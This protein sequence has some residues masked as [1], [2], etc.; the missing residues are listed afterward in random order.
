MAELE[1]ELVTQNYSKSLLTAL[2]STRHINLEDSYSLVSRDVG[3][4]AESR[5]RQVVDSGS[6]HVYDFNGE[7]YLDRLDIGRVLHQSMSDVKGLHFE[8][9][10]SKEGENPF[11]S[12]GPYQETSLLIKDK[13]GNEIFR[14]DDALFPSSWDNPVANSIIAQ[15]YFFKPN[16][17][18]WKQAINDKTGKD[19]EFS[20]V[21][22]IG[23]VTNFIVDEGEKLGYFQSPED[24]KVFADE[25]RWLQINQR[26]AFNSPVQFNA[27]IFNEYGI[28]GNKGISYFRDSKTGEVIRMEEGEYIHPQSHA[29]FIKGPEDTL[30][31]ILGH[32]SDEGA[33]FRNGSGIGQDIGVLRG[34]GEPLSGGG[35]SSGTLSFLKIYDNAAGSIKSGGKSRRAARMTTMKYDHADAIELIRAKPREDHKALILMKAGYEGGMDGEAVRTVSLQN[36]NLSVRA[37][38]E[39]FEKVR[40]GGKVK[41]R[42]VV[43]GAVVDE[44]DAHRMLQEIAYGSWRIGDPAIQYNTKIQEMH[45]CKNSGEQNSTNP[46]SEYLFLDDTSC[47][48]GSHNLLSYSDDKG[49]FDIESYKRAVRITQI[50]QDILNDASSYPVKSIAEISPEFRTTGVGYCNLGALLMRKGLAYDSDEGRAFT[51]AVTA[52]HT[53]TAY[54]ASVEMAE[55]LGT[56]VH[57]E[58]NKKP[59]LE[60]L[61][62]HKSSLDDVDWRL[63]NE[64]GL[65]EAAYG[66]W[67]KVVEGALVHGVRNAQT[68]NLAPTG[69]IS[70]LM[71]ADTTGIEPGISLMIYKS[72][73]GGGSVQLVNKEVPRA[74]RNLGYSSDQ[75]G[76]VVQFI[77][78]NNHV[79]GAP[80]LNPDHYSVFNTALG[81]GKGNGTISLEGHIRILGAAQPF[82]S[83]AISKTCNA[84]HETSVKTI[85][86]SYLLGHDLGLKALAV[87]R[88]NS[89]PTVAL[90][91][92]DRSYVDLGR[93]EKEELPSSGNSFR[94]EVRIGGTPFLINIGEY[95][96]GRPGEVVIESYS[97][98]STLGDT[99]RLTGISASKALKR[100]LDL[101]DV[102]AGWIGHKSEPNGFVTID[103]PK[104]SH[105]FIK[106]A[107]SPFDFLGKHLLIHYKGRT[108]LA[109]DE[110]MVNVEELRGFTHGAFRAYDRMNVDDWNVD[111]VL[112]DPEYGG[113][114]Q[115]DPKKSKLIKKKKNSLQNEDNGNS[116]GLMCGECGNIMKQTKPGCYKCNNCGES[117]GGCGQ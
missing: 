93:G 23:R 49:N 109:T 98:G 34:E 24:K 61:Q 40:N 19:Y 35:R 88:D 82:L 103:N 77:D 1:R 6:V 99:L 80:H 62:K 45:P 84:P 12:A 116:R 75:I 66:S 113:F 92:N 76:D 85:Y 117:V 64:E 10:F 28:K 46:C 111:E 39:F 72:L 63:V 7:K 114:V 68:T 56:F 50:A 47:N 22:L 90:S 95:S 70:Y 69:T 53:G 91:H 71:D 3:S 96:D 36:T 2:N 94:Q 44:I 48:L 17:A 83:G 21:H 4:S 87:F 107:L 73:S 32:V 18:E 16:K 27:G 25:L 57:Y 115:P 58:F 81:D 112:E 67:N 78:K 101:E 41:L 79:I 97:A 65:M 102:V 31:S 43:D 51:G 55:N 106:T 105:P 29:C 26:F 5:L 52:L 89:K 20:P 38:D 59:F 74:L 15:R 11:E 100:G 110:E 33:I 108:E 54:E 8:R 104:G 14:M 37:D 86:D 30:E 9:Y 13:G 42:R 60:V